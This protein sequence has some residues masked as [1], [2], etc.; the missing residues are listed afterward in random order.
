MGSCCLDLQ[1]LYHLDRLTVTK[2]SM[3]EEEQKRRNRE[4][5]EEKKSL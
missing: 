5:E 1:T 2:N 4:E 3:T